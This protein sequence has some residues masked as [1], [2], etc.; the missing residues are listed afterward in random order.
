MY[1]EEYNIIV[2]FLSSIGFCNIANPIELMRAMA[3]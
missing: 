1:I 2:L 3:N